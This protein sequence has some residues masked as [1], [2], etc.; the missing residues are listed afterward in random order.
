MSDESV[1]S[2]AEWGIETAKKTAASVA[3]ETHKTL[4]QM[5]ADAAQKENVIVGAV[6]ESAEVAKQAAGEA[7]IAVASQMVE[8]AKA[9][10]D[11]IG[12]HPAA[13]IGTG[14]AIGLLSGLLIRR[15]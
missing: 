14:I 13:A 1:F 2:T 3:T 15:G 8:T 10:R 12:A 9:T 7:K 6:A 11:F 5:V 4:D